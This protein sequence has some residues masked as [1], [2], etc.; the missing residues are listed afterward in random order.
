VYQGVDISSA[1]SK[2]I[3]HLKNRDP[4][5]RIKAL[6]IKRWQIALI[7]ITARS[8]FIPNIIYCYPCPLPYN[9]N[10]QRFVNLLLTLGNVSVD[11]MGHIGSGI[12]YDILLNGFPNQIPQK[13]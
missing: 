12:I 6:R 1:L 9:H 13:L 10:I 11:F 5:H 4:P 7:H 2:G 8:E 3:R